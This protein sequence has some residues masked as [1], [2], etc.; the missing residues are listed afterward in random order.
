MKMSIN[1]NWQP[2]DKGHTIGQHGSENGIILRDEEYIDQARVTLERDGY[3]PFAI[4]CGIYG[5]MV[6]TCF[7]MNEID[8]QH[9]FEEIK[10]ELE[11]ILDLIPE[12][13]NPNATDKFPTVYQAF[14]DFVDKR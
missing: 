8:A 10:S 4:T 13:D 9:A 14:R 3:Q 7:F 12:Q 6:H 2:F 11:H 5:W 1:Q